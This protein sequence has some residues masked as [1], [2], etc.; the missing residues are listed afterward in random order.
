MAT[1][2]TAAAVMEF[3]R[4]T[5]IPR[6][7]RSMGLTDASLRLHGGQ[8]LI[9]RLPTGRNAALL[10]DACCG[11]EAADRGAVRFLG[12]DWQTEP[13][14]RVLGLRASIGR[15]FGQ[16]NW[17]AHMTVADCVLLAQMHH[18]SRPR[19]ELLREAVRLAGEFG[20]PGLP[21]DRPADVADADLQRAACVRAFL[22]SPRLVLLEEPTGRAT[23][24][25]VAPLI[26]QVRRATARGAAAIWFTRSDAVWRHHALAECRHCYADGSRWVE[27]AA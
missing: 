27:V 15:V 16:T 2:T 23:A 26:N 19:R 25:I 20:L 14:A 1:A 9:V 10:A 5:L 13:Y 22:G 17:V 6:D 24:D 21:V 12:R 11:V 4:V 8:V 7:Q 18:S 3:D